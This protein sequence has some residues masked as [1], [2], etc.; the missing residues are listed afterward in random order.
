MYSVI[1]NIGDERLQVPIFL[2]IFAMGVQKNFFEIYLQFG[3]WSE[4]RFTSPMGRHLC[5]GLTLVKILMVSGD[6]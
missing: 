6:L 5:Y 4:K 3:M 2:F 1:I